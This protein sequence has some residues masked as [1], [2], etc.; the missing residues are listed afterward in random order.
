MV[1]SK[2]SRVKQQECKWKQ[3]DKYPAIA[4]LHP[5]AGRHKDKEKNQNQK[6]HSTQALS[7]PAVAKVKAGS[8]SLALGMPS[9]S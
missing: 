7:I 8:N 2:Q 5:E 9:G 4:C 6:E 1:K 3:H